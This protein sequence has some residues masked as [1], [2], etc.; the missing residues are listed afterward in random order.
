MKPGKKTLTGL[1][2]AAC[3]LSGIMLAA[4]P[5]P[6]IHTLQSEAQLDSLVM[7]SLQQAGISSGSIRARNVEIDTSFTRKEIRIEVPPG[8][9]KTSYHLDLHR[10]MMDLNVGCPARV[11]LP[12][13]DMNIYLTFGGTVH[14]TLRLITTESKPN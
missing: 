12:E 4:T 7:V 9:S 5:S 10:Q 1:L 13:K 2:A 3:I 14:R 6:E 11:V 8:F